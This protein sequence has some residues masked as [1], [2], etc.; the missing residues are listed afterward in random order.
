[1]PRVLALIAQSVIPH[2]MERIGPL[3]GLLDISLWPKYNG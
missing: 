1:M 3:D 2:L